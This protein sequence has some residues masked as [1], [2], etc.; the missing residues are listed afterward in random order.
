MIYT[1]YTTDCVPEGGS[2]SFAT[3]NKER[4]I[5]YANDWWDKRLNEYKQLHEQNKKRYPDHYTEL[6]MDHFNRFYGVCVN[7]WPDDQEPIFEYMERDK[8]CTE[9]FTIGF[10]WD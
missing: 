2:V 4:A 7:E 9:V 1:V 5:K 10:E 6:D 8:M 3:S